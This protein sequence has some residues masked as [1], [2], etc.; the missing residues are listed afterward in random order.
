MLSVSLTPAIAKEDEWID[1]CKIGAMAAGG[2]GAIAPAPVAI[3]AAGFGAGGGVAGGGF[4]AGLQAIGAA[5]LGP[6]VMAALADVSNLCRKKE[7]G[8]ERAGGR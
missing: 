2:V 7:E 6:A 1:W 8:S 5:G 3:G 4:V